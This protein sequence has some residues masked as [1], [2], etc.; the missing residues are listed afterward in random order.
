[1][2]IRSGVEP[3]LGRQYQYR[4]CRKKNLKKES[5]YLRNKFLLRNGLHRYT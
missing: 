4:T 3:L 5:E 1:M 2:E